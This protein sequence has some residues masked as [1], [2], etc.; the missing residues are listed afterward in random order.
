MET[1][2]QMKTTTR[3]LALVASALFLAGTSGSVLAQAYPSKPVQMI[4]PLPAGG[5][6]D[7]MARVLG[8][9]PA[10]ALAQPVIVVN[11][12]GAAGNLGAKTVAQAAP[13]GYTLLLT[14]DVALTAN[15]ALYGPKMGF[16]PLKDLRPIT[17][18]AS[19]GQTLAVHPSL[20][21]TTLSQ[22]IDLAKKQ[23]LS[24]ASAGNASSG[25]LMM[26]L[27]G[28]LAKVNMTHI[29]YKGAAPALND[30]VGGQV[31][32]G[33]LV[34]P[35]VAPY[36][37]A[38]KLVPLAVSSRARSRLLPNVPTVAEAGFPNATLEFSTVLMAPA[39]T[40]DALVQLLREE[41]R[42]ALDSAE[43]RKLL[44]DGD[45]VAVAD[46]PEQAATRL[47]AMKVRMTDLIQSVGIKA[48]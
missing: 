27:L 4:V 7:A 15:P 13:D 37:N 14:L 19:F 28:S 8:E 18:L 41:A 34:T 36:A 2:L 23:D 31:Q 47:A 29:P 25:H 20:K 10:K 35:G 16:D 24:Y 17:T 6:A 40:P 42:K 12:A 33:F 3:R 39:G 22:F 11:Q 21:V 1:Q 30:M 38:G 9:R 48:D 43:M 5:P 26:A 46:T 32:A 44:S 45:Y